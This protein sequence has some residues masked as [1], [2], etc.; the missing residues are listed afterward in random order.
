M[1]RIIEW[2]LPD[3]ARTTCP[4]PS[5]CHGRRLTK[6]Y[7]KKQGLVKNIWIGSGMLMLLIPVPPF[8]IA[9]MLFTTF[10]SFVILD[11][12]E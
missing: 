2:L 1:L 11:E 6:T 8:F 9:A 3:W 4:D 7:Q 10:L 5:H 12:T